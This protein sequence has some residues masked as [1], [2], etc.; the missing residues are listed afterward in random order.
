M[1][2]LVIIILIIIA[3]VELGG[4]AFDKIQENITAEVTA[5]DKQVHRRADK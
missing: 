2:R 3:G 4:I 1:K 5:M